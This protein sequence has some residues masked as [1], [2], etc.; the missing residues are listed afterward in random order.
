MTPSEVL[1]KKNILLAHAEVVK[2]YKNKLNGTKEG[3][4]GMVF[5]SDMYYPKDEN[6]EEDKK[7]AKRALGYADPIFKSDYPEEMKERLKDRLI[8]FTK[9]E[10]NLIF[11]S[12]N[13]FALNYL[14]IKAE[15]SEGKGYWHDRDVDMKEDE[16]LK[17]DEKWNKTDM[18]WPIVPKGIH[19][20]LVKINEHYNLTANNIPILITENR[21]TNKE[22]KE[23][24]W[25]N[26]QPRIH[27]M[28]TYLEQVEKAI[29]E[30]INIQGYTQSYFVFVA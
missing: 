17:E 5:N 27:Y 15:K 29:D 2:I 10:K 13:F 21:I 7:A 25:K 9:E 22:K 8:P 30:G 16:K 6:K 4:I 19:G 1:T 23:E 12:S 18:G 24:D 20:L 11:K 26:D 3:K 14:T 28:K